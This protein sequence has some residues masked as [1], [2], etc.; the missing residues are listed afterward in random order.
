MSC[1]AL[2]PGEKAVPNRHVARPCWSFG[3]AGWKTSSKQMIS[4]FEP[5]GFWELGKLI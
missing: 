1:P 5:C 4:G 2:G 3:L